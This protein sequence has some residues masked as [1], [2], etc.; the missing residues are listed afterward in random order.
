[1]FYLVR[2]DY[3]GLECTKYKE[4]K[5]AIAAMLRDIANKISDDGIDKEDGS[6]QISQDCAYLF[7]SCASRDWMIIEG[8]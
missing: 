3:D 6:L 5:D 8:K 1:M 7:A 2:G 4:R